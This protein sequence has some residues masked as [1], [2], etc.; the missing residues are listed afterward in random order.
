[1]GNVGSVRIGNLAPGY[2][3]NPH[4][5][6]A[7]I[8]TGGWFFGFSMKYTQSSKNI[9]IRPSNSEIPGIKKSCTKVVYRRKTL[10]FEIVA[11]LRLF[12][13]TK[14]R[15]DRGAASR[16]RGGPNPLVV[17]FTPGMGHNET[18][19]SADF[20]FSFFHGSFAGLVDVQARTYRRQ[21]TARGGLSSFSRVPSER[22]PKPPWG[23]NV[24]AKFQRPDR[25]K[26]SGRK[27]VFFVD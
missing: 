10:E 20:F 23:A 5:T 7:H 9:K 26:Y 22:R 14:Q 19:H 4:I 11:R 16:T 18:A 25:H 8:L 12:D 6:K 17:W 13:A 24:V 2:G 1:M 21:L 3:Y 27:F 15:L